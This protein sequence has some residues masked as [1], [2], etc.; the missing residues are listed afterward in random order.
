VREATKQKGARRHFFLLLAGLHCFFFY[1]FDLSKRS[2][3]EK[4][5][6]SK[7]LLL[8]LVLV[9]TYMRLV[10]ALLQVLVGDWLR[11]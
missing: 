2:K 6:P 3:E 8:V 7:L 11:L 5:L 1:K 4:P 10:V 9:G